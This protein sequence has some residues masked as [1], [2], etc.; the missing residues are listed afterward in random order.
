MLQIKVIES[1]KFI[2]WFQREGK[3]KSDRP[4]SVCAALR[5]GEEEASL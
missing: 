4:S 2:I 3:V 5:E 1:Q